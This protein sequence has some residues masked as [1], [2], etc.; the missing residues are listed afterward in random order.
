MNIPIESNMIR[1]AVFFILC[2]LCRTNIEIRAPDIAAKKNAM[3]SIPVCG[4]KAIKEVSFPKLPMN[5]P[6]T[7]A[8]QASNNIEP[9]P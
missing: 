2:L 1:S 6:S 8:F 9:L 4:M 3:N 7:D 5:T